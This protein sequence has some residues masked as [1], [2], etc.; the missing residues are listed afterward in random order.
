MCRL[1]D[2]FGQTVQRYPISSAFGTLLLL[3]VVPNFMTLGLVGLERAALAI[4]LELEELLVAAFLIGAKW[5]SLCPCVILSN[6]QWA[7]LM[8]AESGKAWAVTGGPG[9]S[10]YWYACSGVV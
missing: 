1:S 10:S 2:W 4:I 7:E 6:M 8:K 5:V 3:L 9:S